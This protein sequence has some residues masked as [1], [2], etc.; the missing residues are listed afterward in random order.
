MQ[1]VGLIGTGLMERGGRS[2][3]AWHV[4]MHERNPLP[5]PCGY[6]GLT[7]CSPPQAPGL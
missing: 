6:Q 2:P 7:V 5:A 4:A 3:R 1:R